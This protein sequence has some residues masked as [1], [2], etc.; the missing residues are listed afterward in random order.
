MVPGFHVDPLISA[1]QKYPDFTGIVACHEGGAAMMA[2]G[3]AKVSGKFGVVA[4]IGG[5]GNYEYDDR[6]YDSF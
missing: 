6:D 3:Y 4:G 1:L 2:D 5:P